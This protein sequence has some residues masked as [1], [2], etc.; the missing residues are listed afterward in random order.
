M[1]IPALLETCICY[2]LCK[3]EEKKKVGNYMQY[4]S[5]PCKTIYWLLPATSLF[6]I[7]SAALGDTNEFTSLLLS[8]LPAW[9]SPAPAE[10]PKH[11]RLEG[12][13]WGVPRVPRELPQESCPD[14]ASPQQGCAPTQH[15]EPG[16]EAYSGAQHC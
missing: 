6:P 1:S 9:A 4:K 15:Y 14:S 13:R 11:S 3:G 7:V 16:F 2:R 8:P 5:L 10:E 12:R